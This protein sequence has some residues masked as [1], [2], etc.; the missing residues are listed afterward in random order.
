MTIRDHINKWLSVA[1][2]PSQSVI[3]QPNDIVTNH[4]FDAFSQKKRYSDL[5]NSPPTSY[6]HVVLFP[7][8][9][10]RCTIKASGRN[11][12][13]R[14]Q[15][16]NWSTEAWIDGRLF[17]GLLEVSSLRLITLEIE[18]REEKRSQPRGLCHWP[19]HQSHLTSYLTTCLPL[20]CSRN[21][22]KKN[23]PVAVEIFRQFL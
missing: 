11:K 4:P 16:C 1:A 12:T 23:T 15:W 20:D 22:T 7:S 3:Q 5:G 2:Q 21:M 10:I 17:N 19:W 9:I 13:M 6:A 14:G 8:F 18:I